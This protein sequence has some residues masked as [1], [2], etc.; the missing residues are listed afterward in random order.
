[1]KD[2]H[3]VELVLLPMLMQE[4]AMGGIRISDDVC[5][6]FKLTGLLD[7]A[8]RAPIAHLSLKD[9]AKIVRRAQRARDICNAQVR[10]TDTLGLITYH[11]MRDLTD[12]GYLEIGE[13]SA[14]FQA[15]TIFME[16]LEVAA[17][18]GDQFEE[19]MAKAVEVLHALHGER[20]FE[21][22]MEM[23]A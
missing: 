21:R 22:A 2:T 9:Q 20:L 8:M 16:S 12:R 17:N 3:Y 23:A 5:G 11:I 1:M 14:L 19:T 4:V 10:F 7:E 6:Y 15:A 13:Q 18:R